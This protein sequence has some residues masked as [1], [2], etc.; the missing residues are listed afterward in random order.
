[1]EI[2]H[3]IQYF[4][5]CLHDLAQNYFNILDALVGSREGRETGVQERILSS[6]LTEMDGIGL[7]IDSS[8]SNHKISVGEI[9]DSCTIQQ[10]KIL[11]W[12]KYD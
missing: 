3:N 9:E 10:V 5:Y 7:R 2:G 6:F 12:L 11:Y 1:M 8:P 4:L